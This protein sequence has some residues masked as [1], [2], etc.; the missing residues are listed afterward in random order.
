MPFALGKS[1]RR[2]ASPCTICQQ[3]FEIV[4]R[5]AQLG[6]EDVHRAERE[7]TE[8]RVCAGDAVDDFVYGAIAAG[9]DDGVESFLRRGAGERFR[10]AA[11]RRR[12]QNGT[13]A[14]SASMRARRRC[15]RSP[16][17]A[18]F[19]MTAIR[20]NVCSGRTGFDLFFKLPLRNLPA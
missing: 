2:I 19:R 16:R 1:T 18:G 5:Q 6:G 14:D 12:L 15:A 7:Q 3:R 11:A 4:D 10:F 17:A 8:R 9:G 20:L 13:A